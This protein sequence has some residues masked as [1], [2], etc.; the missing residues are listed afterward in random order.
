MMKSRTF[1]KWKSVPGFEGLYEV[2]N[3]GNVA[4]LNYRHTGKRK[5]LSQ[6][7]TSSGYTRVLLY[8]DGKRFSKAVHRIVAEAFI[9]NESDKTCI[10]H[11]DENKLNNSADNLE[12]CTH[13]YNNGH[14]TRKE[15]VFSKL[16][17]PVVAINQDGTEEWY[18]SVNEAG[19]RLGKTSGNISSALNGKIKT[20]YGRSWRW[21]DA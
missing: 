2:S 11:K 7:K 1:E 4:S 12:W 19:R 18:P 9:P 8:K 17:Q 6:A 13:S 20:A 21:A 15:R 16:R 5:I 14:G 10:N 3:T